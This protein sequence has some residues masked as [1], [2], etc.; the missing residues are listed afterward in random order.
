MRNSSIILFISILLLLSACT[1]KS[2]N[3]DNQNS[4]ENHS[5]TEGVHVHDDG[6]VHQ[7][8]EDTEH[9]QEEFKVDG[10]STPIKKEE[11]EHSH[12]DGSHQ[13]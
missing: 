9:N 5:T 13:H 2:D 10:D 6:T 8:H 4:T 12:A 3:N 11:T 7:N 1:G